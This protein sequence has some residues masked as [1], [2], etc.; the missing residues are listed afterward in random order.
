MQKI[1]M[2]VSRV[3]ITVAVALCISSSA[4]AQERPN[5]LVIMGDDIA[6]IIHETA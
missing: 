2:I 4:L 1:P 3:V 6:R 5:I